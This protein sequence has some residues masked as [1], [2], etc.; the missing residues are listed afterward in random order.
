LER[1]ICVVSSLR[2]PSASPLPLHHKCGINNHIG[3]HQRHTHQPFIHPTA[4]AP[5]SP[6]VLLSKHP[7]HVTNLSKLYLARDKPL[8]SSPHP[9]FTPSRPT[10]NSHTHTPLLL[11]RANPGIFPHRDSS[12]QTTLIC[13]H[14]TRSQRDRH[15]RRRRTLRRPRTQAR[16][17]QSRRQTLLCLLLSH[18]ARW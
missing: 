3:I 6:P 9:A 11:S 17:A 14:T 1:P 5:G 12:W 13:S 10:V 2:A 7:A 15:Q 8:K 18:H 16:L 4:R